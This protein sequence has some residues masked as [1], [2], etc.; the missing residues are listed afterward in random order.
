[1]TDTAQGFLAVATVPEL[2]EGHQRHVQVEDQEILLCRYQGRYY[3]VAYYCSHEAFPLEGGEMENGCIVCP[4][5]G[6][7]FNLR[8]GVALAPPAF[9]GIKTYPVRVEDGII[10]VAARHSE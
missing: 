6:A 4:Y 2:P 1:M 9:E 10:Y 8:D 3:A 7:E 5:H